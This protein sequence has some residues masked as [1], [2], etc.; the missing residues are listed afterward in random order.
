MDINSK[1]KQRVKEQRLNNFR[2]IYA[3]LQV[4]IALYEARGNKKK[5]EEIRERMESCELS[6]KT[7]EEMPIE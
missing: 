3:N 6:Y 2:I 1:I 4:D 7:I 5:A